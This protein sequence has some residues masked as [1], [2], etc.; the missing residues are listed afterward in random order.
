MNC[1][2]V[3]VGGVA[4]VGKRE[5][6]SQDISLQSIIFEKW[7]YFQKLRKYFARPYCLFVIADT[8]QRGY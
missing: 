1:F 4:E 7:E 6:Q 2:N 3:I 8:I 5:G